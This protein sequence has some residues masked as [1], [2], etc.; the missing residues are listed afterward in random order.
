MIKLPTVAAWEAYAPIW[1]TC[2]NIRF[3]STY[4]LDLGRG[5]M[6]TDMSASSLD[7][8]PRPH[9]LSDFTS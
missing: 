1:R 4:S 2:G 7:M 3:E 8:L 5:S 6:L 9:L